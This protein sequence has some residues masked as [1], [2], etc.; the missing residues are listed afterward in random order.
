MLRV[1]R[2]VPLR[3][4]GE[5]LYWRQI[6]RVGGRRLGWRGEGELVVVMVVMMVMMG[7]RAQGGLHVA[8]ELHFGHGEGHLVS[9]QAGVWGHVIAPELK[10]AGSGA[11][12]PLVRELRPLLPSLTACGGQKGKGVRTAFWRGAGST[13]LEGRK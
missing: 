4:G 10:H 8:G 11:H 5:H 7:V 6:E 2:C 12:W 1:V 9:A 13:I 3:L